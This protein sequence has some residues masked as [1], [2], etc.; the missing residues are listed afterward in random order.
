MT[1]IER[2][3]RYLLLT[4]AAA[5][6]ALVIARDPG[7]DTQIASASAAVATTDCRDTVWPYVA[8]GCLV[9]EDPG[10]AVGPVRRIHIDDN[11]RAGR[12]TEIALL[13]ADD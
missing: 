1:T 3:V 11:T 6:I 4:L 5:G 9:T 13:S 2:S 8:A 12:A 10:A 7:A